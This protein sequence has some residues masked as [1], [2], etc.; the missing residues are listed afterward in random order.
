[1]TIAAIG[2]WNKWN[3]KELQMWNEV[4]F[5]MEEN[6]KQTDPLCSTCLVWENPFRITWKRKLIVIDMKR[7]KLKREK[8]STNVTSFMSSVDCRCEEL[9]EW[10][11]K[12]EWVSEYNKDL[13]TTKNWKKRERVVP[14][15][16]AILFRKEMIWEWLCFPPFR[17]LTQQNPACTFFI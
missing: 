5:E 17:L 6:G 11:Y 14:L 12:V 1:M 13:H 15:L 10:I 16:S 7:R 9:R 3:L 2:K 4:W 8:E